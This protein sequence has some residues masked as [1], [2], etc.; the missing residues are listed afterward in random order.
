MANLSEWQKLTRVSMGLPF[1]N[2]SNGS[3]SSA[4]VPTMTRDSFSGT[5]NQVTIVT[6]GATFS[7]GDILLLHQSRGT[8]VGQWEVNKVVS[9]GGTPTLTLLKQLKYTYTDS[10]ASQAQAIKISQYVNVTVQAGTWGVPSWN[11]DTGGILV[12]A[13][14]GTLTI[15]GTISTNGGNG[16]TT[17]NVENGQVAGGIGG[18]FYGGYAYVRKN[19]AG[20]GGQ[21][22]GTVGGG[23]NQ[24]NEANGSGGGGGET[25]TEHDVGGGAGGGNADAG[26]GGGGTNGGTGGTGGT[27]A[28]S[29]DLITMVFGG[30]GG[31]GSSNTTTTGNNGSGGSGGGIVIIFVKN[32]V[33]IVGAITA[34][35]GLAGNTG[36][37]VSWSRGGDGA[38]GSILIVTSIASIGTNRITAAGGTNGNAGSAGRIAVHHSGTVTGTS[39]PSFSDV[40][41]GTLVEASYSGILEG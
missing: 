10:G 22:E 34:N 14:K 18:G 39:N 31:G 26:T 3:Y 12:F 30:G 11:G 36:E 9:G 35:G 25:L 13:V 17:G 6:S 27:S 40:T 7:N 28:G 16:G 29:S 8:G 4:T 19:S 15:T 2:G 5:I 37:G 41:D 20:H 24:A 23:D 38:G 33:T 21:G 1:G 32:I